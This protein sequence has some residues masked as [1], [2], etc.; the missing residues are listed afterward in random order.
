M[1]RYKKYFNYIKENRK[2][3]YLVLILYF[4]SAVFGYLFPSL[5]QNYIDKFISQI[6][7]LTKDM[8]IIQMFIF[9][10][11][12]N[13][14]TAFFSI[15]FGVAFGIFPIF[16]TFFNGYV[17]GYVTK[18][19]V[20]NN[21]IFYLWRLLPHGIFE[22][23]AVFLSFALGLKLGLILFK[24]KKQKKWKKLWIKEFSAILEIFVYVIL[25]LLLI[26]ALIETGLMFLIK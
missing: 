24:T 9:I 12:N 11:Q 21:G 13:L 23:V 18:S 26:A 16:L 15:L 17:L 14:K 4:V 19:V 1:N 5:F 3:I 2:F 20:R 6:L 22:L 10:F 8:N 7:E 25:P